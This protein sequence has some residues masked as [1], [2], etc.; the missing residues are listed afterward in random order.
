[1]TV[2]H[3]IL[4]ATLCAVTLFAGC[5]ER[6]EG[7]TALRLIDAFESDRSA[8]DA[9]RQVVFDWDFQTAADLEP[10][11]LEKVDGKAEPT[12]RGLAMFSTKADP[13]LWRR[14]SFDAASVGAIRVHLVTALR[15]PAG[16]TPDGDS[17]PTAGDPGKVQLFWAGAGQ[18]FSEARQV[19]LEA[20]TRKLEGGSLVYQLPLALDPMWT[21][22]I[23]RLRV[24]PTNRNRMEIVLG[25]IEGLRHPIQEHPAPRAVELDSEQRRALPVQPDAPLEIEIDVP[26]GAILRFGYGLSGDPPKSGESR[27]ELRMSAAAEGTSA[28]N[29]FTATFPGDGEARGWRTARIDLGGFAGRRLRLRFESSVPVGVSALPAIANPEIYTAG[30]SRRRP[31][32]LLISLDTLRADHLSLY[33]YAHETSPKIDAWAR[34]QAVTFERAVAPSPWTLPSHVSMFTGLDALTHGVN[35]LSTSMSP[36]LPSLTGLLHDAGYHTAAVTG[37]GFVS[38]GYGLERGF[39]RFRWWSRGAGDAGELDAHVETALEWLEELS[40]RPFFLFFHTYEVH[41]PF[42]R[43]EPFFTAFGG[44]PE[45]LAA[46]SLSARADSLAEAQ[47]FKHRHRLFWDGDEPAT[48][49]ESATLAA[50]YDAGVAYVDAAVGRLLEGLRRLDLE[51]DTLVVL[52]SDHGE[53]LGEHGQISHGNLYDDNLLV[54]L[55][56]SYPRQFPDARRVERQ[57]RLIDLVPTVLDVAGVEAPPDLDGVSLLPL[58]TAEDGAVEIPP[59]WSYGGWPNY[60]LALRRDNH[61]YIFNDAPWPALCGDDELYELEN[62]PAELDD[63]ADASEHAGRLRRQLEGYLRRHA[64]GLILEV[65]N[66]GAEP[67]VFD[68]TGGKFLPWSVKWLAGACP[69]VKRLAAGIQVTAEP[70]ES[71]TLVWQRA[72]SQRLTV[73][74]QVGAAAD[75]AE[76]RES[77][78]LDDPRALTEGRTL[79][80]DDGQ[81]QWVEGRVREPWTGVRIWWSEPRGAAAT[82]ESPEV[83]EQL[84]TL[85]YLK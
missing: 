37:G 3:P 43:R 72:L 68:L 38:P 46:N 55:V 78:T 4:A 70:G 34:E 36:E 1:M 30:S 19:A 57:V 7:T 82:T 66:R 14:A 21:G 58:M 84:E 80:H 18:G 24:D 42:H 39:D 75:H 12:E 16:G 77:V 29:L 73:T 52:T 31:N 49:V 79:H 60:G 10:W 83:L 25:R 2:K 71:T 85:G 62:D 65:A 67:I 40:D 33:G 13:H 76:R 28:R 69:G 54:P 20:P 51:A 45:N 59:A 47:G 22:K 56:I 15:Y 61:K 50:L 11:T 32:V 27:T 41:S 23:H 9:S 35:Y 81:W 63:L 17:T 5:G 26:A 48:A 6:R 44:H 53:S 8:V 74:A 64:T